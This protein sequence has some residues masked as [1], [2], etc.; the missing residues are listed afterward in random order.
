M[1]NYTWIVAR[2]NVTGEDSDAIGK[3]GPAGAN[4]RA[5]VDEVVSRGAHFRLLNGDGH[6]CYTGYI[7]GE[8]AGEEPLDEFGRTRGCTRIE[9]DLEHT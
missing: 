4:G 5:G 1:K 2:D 9:Y 3:L 8:F 7:L 6:V